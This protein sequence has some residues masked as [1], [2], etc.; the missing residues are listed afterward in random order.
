MWSSLPSSLPKFFTATN[1][2]TVQLSTGII[3]LNT[4]LTVQPN[5][6]RNELLYRV[7]AFAVILPIL[8]ARAL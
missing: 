3:Q 2:K 6:E 7:N 4:E 1:S 5:I 8:T